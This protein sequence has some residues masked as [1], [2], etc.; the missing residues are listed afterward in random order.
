MPQTDNVIRCTYTDP[1]INDLLNEAGEQAGVFS[2]HY[3]QV[4]ELFFRFEKEYTVPQLPIHHD[5]RVPVPERRY[6]EL[7]MEIFSSVDVID[8]GDGSLHPVRSYEALRERVE[9]GDGWED[10]HCRF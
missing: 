10:L 2:R 4:E 8:R 9:A 1:G 6:V 3:N 7:L 5:V